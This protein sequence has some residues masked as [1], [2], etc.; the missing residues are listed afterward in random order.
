MT[1]AHIGHAGSGGIQGHS[2]GDIY[3]WMIQGKGDS[4]QARNGETGEVCQR[5]PYISLTTG[6]SW[7]IVQASY[8]EAYDLAKAD[9]LRRIWEDTAQTGDLL[10]V[11]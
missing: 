5:H 7:E 8:G 11:A 3:P 4:V 6:A 10:K 1:K 2:V 9:A